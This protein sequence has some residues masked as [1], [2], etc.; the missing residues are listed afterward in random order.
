MRKPHTPLKRSVGSKISTKAALRRK[1]LRLHLTPMRAIKWHC[2]NCSGNQRLEIRDCPILTC[3]CWPLRPGVKVTPADLQ[4][5]ETAFTEDSLNQEILGK[6][7]MEKV[8]DIK[9]E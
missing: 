4:R 6:G 7:E 8:E 3:A 2:K 1:S 5:W 9:F